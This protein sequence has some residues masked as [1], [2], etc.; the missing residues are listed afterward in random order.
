[1][2]YSTC[3]SCA[4]VQPKS[5]QELTCRN[6]CTRAMDAPRTYPD[7]PLGA[8]LDLGADLDQIGCLYHDKE[9]HI[10][11]ACFYPNE[12]ANLVRL[13]EGTQL[14]FTTQPEDLNSELFTFRFRKYPPI[15]GAVRDSEG[16]VTYQSR[17]RC[18]REGDNL[19]MDN[20]A[21]GKVLTHSG[22]VTPWN[23][24]FV[25][26]PYRDA[27]EN[28]D[29]MGTKSYE[30]IRLISE[31]FDPA[32][33]LNEQPIVR[34]DGKKKYYIQFTRTGQFLSLVP[35]MSPAPCLIKTQ[36]GMF[37]STAFIFLGTRHA[38]ESRANAQKEKMLA[39]QRAAQAQIAAQQQ[40]AAPAKANA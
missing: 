7:G 28:F 1:M 24:P 36:G 20:V 25:N 2:S 39:Q 31:D 10:L 37:P 13:G 22:Y 12:G 5:A 6:C 15:E 18:I 16:R 34:V 4:A 33:P 40:Q 9:V 35:G 38:F 3:S 26:V 19:T 21:V 29:Y 23:T 32:V 27:I 30:N 14:Q 11:N 17:G 8:E